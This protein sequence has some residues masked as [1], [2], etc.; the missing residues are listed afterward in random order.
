MSAQIAAFAVATMAVTM[1]G[2]SPAGAGE[3]SA[4][5]SNAVAM[6]RRLAARDCGG[7]HATGRTDASRFPGAPLF[8]DLSRRYPVSTLG[9]ALAEGISVGHP[10]MPQRAYPAA[11]VAALIAYLEDLQPAVPA[12]APQ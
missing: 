5:A 3:G 8:R 11:E 12:A 1:L 7:C 9:E 6:G 10:A 2:A 4:S